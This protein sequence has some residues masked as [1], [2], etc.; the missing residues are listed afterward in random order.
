MVIRQ[1][2]ECVQCLSYNIAQKRLQSIQSQCSS[3][4]IF[5]VLFVSRDECL[6]IFIVYLFI[7]IISYFTTRFV[8]SCII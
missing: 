8:I 4:C 2:P 3:I 5:L 1:V 7:S 6:H